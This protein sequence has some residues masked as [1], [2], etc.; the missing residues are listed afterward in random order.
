MAQNDI[1]FVGSIA[2]DTAEETFRK[3][4]AN[5][6]DHCCFMPDG[7]IGERQY[8][9]THIAHRVFLGHPDLELLERP[10]T[11]DGTEA[12]HPGPGVATS[13]WAFKVKEGV[14]RVR[15]GS[16]GWRL[17]Y[18]RDAINSYFIFKTL[19]KEGVIPA[20]IRFQISIPFVS[21]C[22]RLYFPDP[23]DFAK[24]E[25]GIAEALRLEVR[26][27]FEHLPAEDIALQWDCAIEDTAIEAELSR[28][29]GV[30]TD[31]VH[32]FAWSIFAPALE[33]NKEVPEAAMLGYH[34]CYGTS[35]GWPRRSPQDLSGAVLLLNAAVAQSGRRVDFLHIPTVDSKSENYFDPLGDLKTGGARVYV[36]LVHALHEEGG[37]ETQIRWIGKHL[38]DFG[39]AAPCGFGRGPGKMSAQSGLDSP[40]AYMDGIIKDHHKALETFEKV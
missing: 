20:H 40:N 6:G 19:K 28:D 1:M 4:A 13:N 27:I 25:P 5:F 12:W 32:D 33:L 37:M 39:I 14:D 3:M 31:R 8:W 22:V 24:V 36:G 9:V 23:S 26:T 21:S 15:F 7:E 35:G 17:G 10:L 2:Y 34:A 18:A 16:P 29:G 11:T 38:D 30:L